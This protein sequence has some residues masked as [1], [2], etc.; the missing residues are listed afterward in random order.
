MTER[1]SEILKQLPLDFE[2]RS[3]MGRNDFMISRCN[4]KAFEMLDSWPD[5]LSNG[6]F[7]Y[8]PKGCGKSHL[9]H[10]FTDKLKQ[11]SNGKQQAV[12]VPASQVNTRNVKRLAQ[13]NVG[14]VVENVYPQHNDESLFHLFNM[15]NEEGKYM[16]WTAE[17]PVNLMRFSLPDL[18]TRL[19]MLPSVEIGEPD[20]AMLQML[21]AKQFNDRQIIIGQDIL[22]YIINNSQRS[23]A[24]IR[25]LVKEIDEVSL[26]HQCAVNYNVVKIAMENL[27]QKD[28][29]EPD[30]FDEY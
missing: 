9:A 23:F 4:R 15:F 24:Y 20:D 19:N 22:N 12:I 16:L 27:A 1:G 26:A 8:G 28:K 14:I 6:L 11:C 7:I 10:L 18:Q 3:Y 5:W 13:E 17:K 2:V 25:D 29:R 30:L 21:V